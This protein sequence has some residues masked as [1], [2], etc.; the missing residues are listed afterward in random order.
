MSLQ[1]AHK[2]DDRHEYDERDQDVHQGPESLSL[3]AQRV[4]HLYST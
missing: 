1:D 3:R 4:E 2:Y